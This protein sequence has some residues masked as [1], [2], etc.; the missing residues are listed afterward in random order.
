MESPF[1]RVVSDVNISAQNARQFVGDV[2][3]SIVETIRGVLKKVVDS[4]QGLKMFGWNEDLWTCP[5]NGKKILGVECTGVT[6]YSSA[7]Q[8]FWR[9]GFGA[10]RRQ[11]RGYSTQPRDL[12]L[13]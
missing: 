9:P 10:G 13:V 4:S 11:R 6:H 8:R 12:R 5:S 1:F 7:N 3:L 2:Y